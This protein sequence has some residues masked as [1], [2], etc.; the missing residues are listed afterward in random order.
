M[1]FYPAKGGNQKPEDHAICLIKTSNFS[2]THEI[3]ITPSNR[4]NTKMFVKGTGTFK[5]YND[6]NIGGSNCFY[7]RPNNANAFSEADISTRKHVTID[8]GYSF[9]ISALYFA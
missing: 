5:L 4:K 9:N 8:T 7:F 6:D 2:T 3:E 1:S